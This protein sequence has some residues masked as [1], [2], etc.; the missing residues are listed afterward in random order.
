VV[1]KVVRKNGPRLEMSLDSTRLLNLD[2]PIVRANG[3]PA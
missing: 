2:A 1:A 3:F